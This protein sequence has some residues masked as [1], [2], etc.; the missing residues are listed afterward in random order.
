MNLH[1]S[2]DDSENKP[3]VPRRAEGVKV[4]PLGQ[5]VEMQI[6]QAFDAGDVNRG[7]ALLF[8]QYYPLLCSHAVRYVASKVIAEDIVSEL[9]YEFQANQ[10]YRTVTT[11]FRAFLFTSVRNRAFNYIRW[12][13]KRN[14]P[15][16]ESMPLSIASGSQP[17][18]IT[19]FEEIYQM[20]ERAINEMPGQ[21]KQVFMLH[22]FEGISNGKIAEM[23]NLSLR[24]VETHMY[25]AKQHLRKLFAQL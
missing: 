24:T 3:F 25:L 4:M 11:S 13:M 16:D 23:M 19:Q 20:M 18:S 12:E 8:E 21:R 6:K 1:L 9:F 22:R 15:L 17:D 7:M 14:E 10:T 5:T 2:P